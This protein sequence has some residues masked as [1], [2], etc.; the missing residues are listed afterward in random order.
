MIQALICDLGGVLVRTEDPAPRAALAAAHGLTWEA[1]D[2][3][4]FRSE[5]A[6]QATRGQISAVEHKRRTVARLG[7]PAAQADDFFR[8]FFAGDRLNEPL[9]AWLRRQ[10]GKRR[11]VLLS[12]AWDDLPALLESWGMAD[13]FEATFISAQI[14]LAKPDP[15]IYRHL[16]KRLQLPPENTLFIDDFSE[17]IA[18]ARALGMQALHFQ[19][20]QSCLQTLSQRFPG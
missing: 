7:L 13:L 10:K 9:L 14:G 2:A 18:A 8:Q 1:L 20:T 6:R 17:N 19:D 11:L 12:N 5:S 15:D 16:L 4:V 3:L